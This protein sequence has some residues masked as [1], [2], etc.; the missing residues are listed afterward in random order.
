MYDTTALEAMRDELHATTC[1]PGRWKPA[2][3]YRIQ[4]EQLI[5][6]HIAAN[7]ERE[8]L[9]RAVAL[10]GDR[11]TDIESAAA[12]AGEYVRSVHEAN[13]H[14]VDVVGDPSR[15]TG[16]AVEQTVGSYG[17]NPDFPIGSR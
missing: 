8:L 16:Q 15:A 10:A 4:V 7:A 2:S 3:Q 9:G 1:H 14:A 6:S 11:F 13:G 12:A 5:N 17:R